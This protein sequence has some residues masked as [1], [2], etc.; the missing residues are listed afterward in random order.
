[1]ARRGDGSNG[2]EQILLDVPNYDFNWQHIYQLAQPLSLSPDLKIEATAT[3]DN[4]EENLV[5]PDPSATVRWG[6]QTWQE[7][8]VGFLDV[9]IPKGAKLELPY[10]TMGAEQYDRRQ[11]AADELITTFDRNGDGQLERS[12]T[13]TQFAIFAFHKFDRNDDEVITREEARME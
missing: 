2:A 11:V 10:S 4:S 5:N 12:E 6:D 13:P 1:V 3:F 9:A 7:M 8:M